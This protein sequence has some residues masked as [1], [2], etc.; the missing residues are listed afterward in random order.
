MQPCAAIAPQTVLWKPGPGGTVVLPPVAL[1]GR[2]TTL[3]GGSP[4]GV[5]DQAATECALGDE[6]VVG[7]RIKPDLIGSPLALQH[8]AWD[9]AAYAGAR[10]LV[11]DHRITHTSTGRDYWRV[12]A[13]QNV[14][15][16]ARPDRH[17]LRAGATVDVN[18]AH[19]TE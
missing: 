3:V 18:I 4:S 10:P 11:D 6:V 9:N 13:K 15:P 5:P 12:A 14:N 2:N 1:M 7:D 17:A 8:A 19:E 16:R